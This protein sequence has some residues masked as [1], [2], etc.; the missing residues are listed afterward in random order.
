MHKLFPLLLG[1]LLASESGLAQ[2]EGATTNIRAF[3]LLATRIGDSLNANIATK[4]SV[5]VVLSVRPEGSAWLVEGEIARALQEGGR[6]VV[7]SP[8]GNY[9]AELGVLGMHVV[10]RDPRSEGLFSGKVV[11]REVT[12]DMQAKLVDQQT[13][14]LVVNKEFREV[15]VDTVRMAEIPTLEDPNVPQT[16]GTRPSEGFFSSLAEPLI[17][18]GA[19]AVAVYLL[20]TVRS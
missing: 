16:Q 6:T 18:L 10:Y 1:L 14:I 13:G 2:G 8:P 3:Q 4:D 20:F 15:M 5:R 19:V 11:D 9:A 12:L 7:V 17:M